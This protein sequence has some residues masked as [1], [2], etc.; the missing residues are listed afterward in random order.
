M[1]H[2]PDLI[3]TVP[4]MKP[5]MKEES[6]GTLI[7]AKKAILAGYNVKILRYGI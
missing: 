4:A 5:K 3:F 1:R 2:R 6:M 7:L